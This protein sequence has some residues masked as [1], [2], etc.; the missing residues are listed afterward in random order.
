[1]DISLPNGS[2][3]VIPWETNPAWTHSVPASRR[4]QGR[5][6]SVTLRAFSLQ[7]HLP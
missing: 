1:M 3:I 7:V 6:I 4:F 5:R 2:V